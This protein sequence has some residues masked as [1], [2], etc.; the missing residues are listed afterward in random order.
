MEAAASFN[1]VWPERKPRPAAPQ[2]KRPAKVEQSFLEE[3]E[4]RPPWLKY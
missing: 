4:L 2:I 1:W 3:Y